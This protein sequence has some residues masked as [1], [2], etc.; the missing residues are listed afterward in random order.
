M[1]LFLKVFAAVVLLLKVASASEPNVVF[2]DSFQAKLQPGWKWVLE[3]K[4]AWKAT[5]NGLTVL[6]EPGNMWGSQ[7]NAKNV[8]VREIPDLPE[9]ETVISVTVSNKPTHQY[10][11]VDLVW[12]YNDSYQVKIGL[13]QVDEKLTIV[14]GRE[15]KDRTRTIII[16]PVDFYT[17][18]LRL[19]RSG[20]QIKGEFKKHGTD[21]WQLAGQ[22]DL[23]SSEKPNIA[24][25][26]YQGDPMVKHWAL[27]KNFSVAVGPGK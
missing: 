7:N 10:E 25:Q 9:K 4:D 6:I 2:K 5:E 3:N 26:C 8:L 13:E 15:E 16:A 12:Y 11:Q 27:L 18:D 14:M 1:Q 23:P 24:L 17:V 21:R 19:T 20:N 22:C